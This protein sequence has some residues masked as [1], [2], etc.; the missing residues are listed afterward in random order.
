MSGD[1]SILN[2]AAGD[3]KLNFS[4]ND[5]AERIRAARIVRDMIRRGY[6]LLVEV[7]RDGKKAYER[8]LDFREDTCSYIIADFD[9]Q[10]DSKQSEEGET[11]EPGFATQGRIEAPAAPEQKKKTR[12]RPR[13]SIPAESTNA[14]AVARSAGG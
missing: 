11:N 12:G 10:R 8:A 6:A 9:P 13:R 7:E 1:V 2:V 3:M 4:P 5:P 14:V